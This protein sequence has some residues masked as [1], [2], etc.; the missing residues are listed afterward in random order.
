MILPIRRYPA[1]VLRAPA[2]PVTVIDAELRR[3]AADM[4]E[5]MRHA[6]GVG[7]AAPQVGVGLRMVVVEV[8]PEKM[9]QAETFIN[10]VIVKRSRDRQDGDEGCL[11]F[12]G[13]RA[14][15]RRAMRVTVSAQ[16]LAGEE[17]EVEAEGLVARAFQHE[18]DHLDG[19]LFVDK[20]APAQKREVREDLAAMEDVFA[21]TA[22]NA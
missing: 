21:L 7:L 18:L 16:N 10:P 8:N 4:A 19:L 15:L 3:L 5:T 20:L 13:I 2:R 6:E 1:P 11:S 17:I 12:P 9:D 14:K 22:D